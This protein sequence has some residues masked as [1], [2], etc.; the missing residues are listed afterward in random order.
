MDT[1]KI[2]FQA[3]RLTKGLAL[4]VLFF[5]GSAHVTAVEAATVCCKC[6]PVADSSKSVCLTGTADSCSALASQNTRLAGQ[7]TCDAASLG[8]PGQGSCK[9]TANGGVCPSSAVPIEGYTVPVSTENVRG[10]L[11]TTT[12]QLNTPIPGLKFPATVKTNPQTGK[13]TFTYLPQYISAASNYAFSIVL[14]V[15]AVMIVYGGFLYL[16]GGTIQSINRGR[17]VIN[18]ALIGLVLLMSAYVLLRTVNPATVN[19]IP[20]QITTVVPDPLTLDDL[21]PKEAQGKNVEIKQVASSEARVKAEQAANTGSSA[22]AQA[23]QEASAAL[24]DEPTTVTLPSAVCTS[25]DACRPYCDGTK[26][27]PEVISGMVKQSELV[28]IPKSPGLSGSGKMRKSAVAALI[29]AGQK[30]N[31]WPGGPYTIA[32]HETY[33]TLAKQFTLACNALGTGGLGNNVAPPGASLHGTGLAI[34]I[35]LWKGSEKLTSDSFSVSQQ[36]KQNTPEN[37]K[38]LQDIMS[39][40]GWVRYCHEIWHFEWGTDSLPSPRFKATRSKSC[41]WPPP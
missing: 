13:A 19:N 40:V 38:L 27:Q 25:D 34:D 18:E 7:I 31:D 2:S 39:S 29:A 10:T 22:P 26:P 15:A 1:R 35:V 8:E 4:A 16:L 14:V 28:S 21:I 23:G 41:P 20:L 3:N 11:K 6:A 24:S 9:P 33:R 30:A 12:P 32:I 17:E 37:V 5:V 36:V